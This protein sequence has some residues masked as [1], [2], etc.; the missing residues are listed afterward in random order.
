MAP[1]I[2]MFRFSNIAGLQHC[3]ISRK[4][5]GKSDNKVVRENLFAIAETTITSKIV[6]TPLVIIA[7]TEEYHSLS[8][9]SFTN[10]PKV[11][12]SGV[13]YIEAMTVKATAT[14]KHII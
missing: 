3:N 8:N 5:V 7:G 12:I 9:G 4:R 2:P 1:N 14:K 13:E 11:E 6:M 10:P